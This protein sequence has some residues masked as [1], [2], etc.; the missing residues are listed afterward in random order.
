[1]IIVCPSARAGEGVSPAQTRIRQAAP[2]RK[3]FRQSFSLF[4]LIITNPPL[5]ILNG[6]DRVKAT[7]R[8]TSRVKSSENI[9]GNLMGIV[10]KGKPGRYV[11]DSSWTRSLSRE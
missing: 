4:F 2:I 6:R 9:R 5:R 1:M 7:Q 11:K 10:F 8:A 3:Q